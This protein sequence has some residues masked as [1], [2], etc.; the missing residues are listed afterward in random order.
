M[1]IQKEDIDFKCLCCN[2]KIF[3]RYKEINS[4][5][6][7]VPRGLTRPNNVNVQLIKCSNCGLIHDMKTF[8]EYDYLSLYTEKKI[9]SSKEYSTENIKSKYSVDIVDLISN[10][11]SINDKVLEIGFCTPELMLRVK[12]LTSHIFGLELDPEAVKKAKGKNIDAR[13]GTINE[14]FKEETFNLIYSIALFEHIENPKNF[15]RD[16]DS[17]LSRQGKIII[18]LPNPNSLNATIS[19]LF[20]KNSWDMFTE[21]GHVAH[22]EKKHLDMIFDKYNYNR[23]LYKTSTILVRGKIPF[24]PGRPKKIEKLV[25]NLS[26]NIFFFWVYKV[27]IKFIDFFKLGDTQILIY[28]KASN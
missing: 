15:I 9:Y 22:Y 6:P 20:S 3:I 19:R 7:F 11:V 4:Y 21:P 18:Q 24:I 8:L 1:R 5:M 25:M 13:F 2:S 12:K 23:I 14:V 10:Y 28:E 27:F 17:K 16:L 26:N